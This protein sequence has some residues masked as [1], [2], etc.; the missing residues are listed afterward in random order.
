MIGIYARISR[1]KEDIDRSIHDQVEL[2]I[3]RA[4]ELKLN[5]IVYKESDGT[6]GSLPIEKRPELKRL[7]S[8]IESGKIHSV[9]AYDQSRLERDVVTNMRLRDKFTEYNIKLYYQSGLQINSIESAMAG[10]ILSRVNQYYLEKTAKDIKRTLLR[11]ATEGRRFSFIQFGYAEDIDKKLKIDEK[12]SEIIKL[13]FEMSLNGKGVQTIAEHL[14]QMEIKTAYALHTNNKKTFTTRHGK[15]KEKKD[16]KWVGNTIKTIINNPIYKGQR[17]W[18][19]KYYPVPAIFE[20]WYWEKVNENLKNNSNNKGIPVK[21]TYLLKGLIRCGKCG[22]NYYGRTR[23]AIG[24][25]KPK[26]HYYMCSSKRRS[27]K[28][29]GNRSVSIDALDTLIW[30]HLIYGGRMKEMIE[31]SLNK[32]DSNKRLIELQTK[33]TNLLSKSESLIS[34]KDK[35][36]EAIGLGI[37]TLSDAYNQNNKIKFE[38]LKVENDISNIKRL[39][40]E[41]SE[42]KEQGKKSLSHLKHLKGIS[43]EKRKEILGKFIKNIEIKTDNSGCLINIQFVNYGINDEEYF[44]TRNN[45]EAHNFPSNPILNYKEGGK[46]FIDLKEWLVL[47]KQEYIKS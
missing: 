20:E 15:I 26:D 47:F 11:N 7:I 35:I 29:C 32:S 12:N 18:S 41:V 13:I 1:E 36:A 38:I 8:D 19:G 4:K 43:N 6:S 23:V 27:E 45:K 30:F 42:F 31:L 25:K 33:H 22:S 37:I 16:V 17:Y 10:D 2:G 3:E 39:I 9:F 40:N 46:V 14:N 5:H 24:D 34:Q 28:N 21:H 44:I